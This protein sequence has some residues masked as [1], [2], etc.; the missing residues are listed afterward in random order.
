[1]SIEGFSRPHLTITLAAERCI[2]A[3]EGVK[4]A[5]DYLVQQFGFPRH[6]AEILVDN[7]GRVMDSLRNLPQQA[8]SPLQ[9]PLP[10]E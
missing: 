8:V 6:D 9:I 3:G 2:M 1:M 5:V 7:M 10:L 4:G